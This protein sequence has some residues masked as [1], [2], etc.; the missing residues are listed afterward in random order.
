MSMRGQSSGDF[1]ETS[2]RV[3]LFHVVTRNS[4]G[5][6]AADAFTQANPVVYTGATLV[7]TT[8]AG[9]TKVGVLGG[10][11]AFTRPAVGNNVI[12][13]PSVTAGPTFLAGQRP[14]GIF[15]NDA[16]GNAYENT[17]GPA[18]GRGPYVCGSGTCLGVTLY[19]TKILQATGPGNAGDAL[20]YAAGDLLYASAN[21]LLTKNPDDAYEQL[22]TAVAF[23]TTPVATV[24]GIVKAA[25]DASTPMLVL[26]LRV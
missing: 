25:P 1:K 14:L 4:V 7:S 2:G 19:E 22:L 6:L 10:S 24:M 17:P 26:D 20:T 16:V 9:I 3:Q 8:L 18:S 23:A 5:A 15:L 13:G 11:V 12:G 21:G